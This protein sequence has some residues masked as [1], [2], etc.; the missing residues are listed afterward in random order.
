MKDCFCKVTGEPIRNTLDELR[1]EFRFTFKGVLLKDLKRKQKRAIKTVNEAYPRLTEAEENKIL[2]EPF[3][4]ILQDTLKKLLGDDKNPMKVFSHPMMGG[5]EGSQFA[6]IDPND[7]LRIVEEYG[8]FLTGPV[9]EAHE[10]LWNSVPNDGNPL[11][12]RRKKQSISNSFKINFIAEFFSQVLLYSLNDFDRGGGVFGGCP[13]L[14]LQEINDRAMKKVAEEER[15]L[16]LQCPLNVVYKIIEKLTTMTKPAGSRKANPGP[17]YICKQGDE[18]VTVGYNFR[19]E[20]LERSNIPTAKT[21]LGSTAPQKNIGDYVGNLVTYLIS[22]GHLNEEGWHTR[23]DAVDYFFKN[24]K[25]WVVE[26]SSGSHLVL[27][28][29]DQKKAEAYYKFHYEP[30]TA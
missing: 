21:D 16:R 4:E 23:S 14:S 12:Q 15:R 25:A 13:A 19:G 24:L 22:K 10:A 28:T 3:L 11:E 18:R 7:F 20:N 6:V 2:N 27:G 17:W 30:S 8:Q 29:Q 26:C 9:Y 5:G 1:F